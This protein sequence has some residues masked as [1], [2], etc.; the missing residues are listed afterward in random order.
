MSKE[1]LCGIYP[2]WKGLILQLL[3]CNLLTRSGQ[4]PNLDKIDAKTWGICLNITVK[5]NIKAVYQEVIFLFGYLQ[6]K[7]T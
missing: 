6:E 1:L 2:E 4:T 7:F 3:Q 5:I